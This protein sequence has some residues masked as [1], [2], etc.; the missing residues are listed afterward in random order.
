MNLSEFD[1]ELPPD[2]IAQ[3]PLGERDASRMLLLDRNKGTY[4]D[5]KFR[6]L[7]DLLRGDELVVI[8]SARVLPAR[9]FGLRGGVH[10]QPVGRTNPAKGEFLQTKI[11]VLLVRQ[12]SSNTWEALVRP[13]R[14]LPTGETIVFGGGELEARVEGRGKF[15]LRILQFQATGDFHETLRRLGH[16]PLPPYIKRADE[17]EAFQ[18]N[19]LVALANGLSRIRGPPT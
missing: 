19:E 18:M 5:L 16:I 15:G 3:H 14:K 9:L 10:A 6:E 2:R 11:E 1:Y 8:N 4:E 17:A 7:P 12:I 13:G